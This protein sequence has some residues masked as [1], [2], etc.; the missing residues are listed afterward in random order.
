MAK[1]YKL[2]IAW[3]TDL[4]FDPQTADNQSKDILKLEQWF[5]PA[6]AIR[7]LTRDN[8]ELLS[9]SGKRNPYPGK[10]GVIEEGALADILLVNGD[11]LV[12]LKILG[13]PEKNLLVIM[14]DG[15]VFKNILNNQ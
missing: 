9:L 14:K 15:K 3:G 7:M 10:L 5:T 2:K 6:E 4:M 1:K 8:A 13:E 12:D 11:P